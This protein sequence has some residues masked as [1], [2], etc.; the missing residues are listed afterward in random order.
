[1]KEEVG[2][3]YGVEGELD[4]RGMWWD[5]GGDKNGSVTPVGEFFKWDVRELGGVDDFDDGEE[6]IGEGIGLVEKV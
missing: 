3:V 5:V 6:G 4:G 1:M 2:I